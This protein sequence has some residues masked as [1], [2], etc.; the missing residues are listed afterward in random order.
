V[1]IGSVSATALTLLSPL[2]R[3]YD[4]DVTFGVVFERSFQNDFKRF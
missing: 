2:S 3:K 4:I 1:L